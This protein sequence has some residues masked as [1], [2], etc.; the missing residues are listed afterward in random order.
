MLLP[1]ARQ[2]DEDEYTV[3][4]QPVAPAA[5][6][7]PTG[8]EISYADILSSAGVSDEEIDS[9]RENIL[10]GDTDYYGLEPLDFSSLDETDELLG[11]LGID[12]TDVSSLT[13]VGDTG[14]NLEGANKTPSAITEMALG[15]GDGDPDAFDPRNLGGA[16]GYG[17]GPS[18]D[19]DETTDF[20]AV[21]TGVG[22]TD[23][24][25]AT[26]FSAFENTETDSSVVGG[27]D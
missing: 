15:M 10:T 19:D 12:P 27:Y 1:S 9:M 17:P 23:D 6:P 24:D 8:S 5:V 4:S 7:D 22:A 26:D 3:M 18:S 13:K 21:S 11:E 20:S 16:E 14:I 2:Y 25:L